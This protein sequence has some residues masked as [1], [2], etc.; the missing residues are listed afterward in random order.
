M[1]VDVSRVETIGDCTLYLGDCLE[2]LPTLGKVDAV[3]TDPPYGVLD[4][5]WDDMTTRELHRFTMGWLA[6]VALKSDTLLTFF[7]QEKRDA[8]DPLLHVLFDEQRQLIWNKQGGRVSEDGMFYSYEPIYYC[9]PTRTWAVCEPKALEVA[10]LLKMAREAAGLS[11]GGVD[12]IVRGK[13]TGLCYRWEEAACLPTPEQVDLLRP[14][15]LLPP[16]FDTAY[17]AA[18]ANR[19]RVVSL[20]REQASLNAARTCDVFSV[21]PSQGRSGRHP[22]EKPLQLMMEL[23]KVLN[24]ADTILDPFMGSG[25]TGVACVNLGRKFIGIEIEPRYFDIACRRIEEAYRQ[26]RL[27]TEPKPAAK[28]EAFL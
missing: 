9:H 3:V 6:A 27:F 24:G 8:I 13:K 19:D 23:L 5:T 11:K 10:N 26:P 4:E 28:Q 25:T 7:A 21:S 17:Q 18:V 15:M 12:M 16:G 22:T 20:A 2:I 14:A 1:G